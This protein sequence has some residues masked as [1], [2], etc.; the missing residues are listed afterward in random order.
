[1]PNFS[2]WREIYEVNSRKSGKTIT[3]ADRVSRENIVPPDG[4]LIAQVN[5]QAEGLE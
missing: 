3:Y 2:G 5:L 4:V 1:V